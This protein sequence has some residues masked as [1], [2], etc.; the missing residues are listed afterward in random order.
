MNSELLSEVALALVSQDGLGERLSK[1]LKTLCTGLQLSRAYVFFEGEERATMGYIHEWCAEG[2]LQ[3]WM[4]DVPYTAY[5]SL[6]RLLMRD[7]QI[8]ASDVAVLPDELRPVYEQ[9]NIRSLQV[10]P[11]IIDDEI[12]G[13]SAFDTCWYERYWSAEETALLKAASALVSAFC[14][15]ELMRDQFREEKAEYAQS[16]AESSIRDAYTGIYSER[17]VFDRLV[18]FDAEYARLGR[19]FCVCLLEVEDFDSI[20]LYYGQDAAT[21]MLKELASILGKSIRP[22]DLVGRYSENQ[23]ILVSVNEDAHEAGY[24]FKRIAAMLKEHAFNFQGQEMELAFSHGIADSSEF[25]AEDM[26]IE[27][28]VELAGNRLKESRCA[29]LQHPVPEEKEESAVFEESDVSAEVEE[30]AMSEQRPED[31]VFALPVAEGKASVQS[32]SSVSQFHEV[33]PRPVC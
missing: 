6:K 7:A 26:S 1:V 16:A 33:L 25:S 12:A 15:R 21:A 5:A 9:H 18:G 31:L 22:Y 24:L 29:I 13:F 4:Q 32:E 20:S 27:K 30:S 28:M 17:Y 2:V 23:F 14:E 19:N 10:W 8:I 3:Q 11:I